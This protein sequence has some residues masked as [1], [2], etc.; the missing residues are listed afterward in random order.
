M[1]RKHTINIARC[2]LELRNDD[3]M[4]DEEKNQVIDTVESLICA[5]VVN[6]LDLGTKDEFKVKLLEIIEWLKLD[7]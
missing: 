7:E 2:F 6:Q 5:F 1:N 3:G 4:A